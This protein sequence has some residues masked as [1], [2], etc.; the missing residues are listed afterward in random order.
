MYVCMCSIICLQCSDI[1]NG[2]TVGHLACKTKFLRRPL[3]TP[4]N[5]VNLESRRR[6][7]LCVF[8]VVDYA[9]DSFLKSPNLTQTIPNIGG[10]VTGIATLG[11]EIFV[12]RWNNP[13]IQVYKSSAD[14]TNVQRNVNVGAGTNTFRGLAACE[15]NQCLYVSEQNNLIIHK[16]SP[17]TNNTVKH[18]S[19]GGQPFGVTVNSAHNLLVACYNTHKVQEYTTDGAMVREINLQPDI[20]NPSYVVQ[21]QGDEFGVIENGSVY[22]YCVVGSDGKIVKSTASGQISSPYGFAVSKGGSKVFVADHGNNRMLLLNSK[23]LSVE[24]LPAA[25]NVGFNAPYC[26]HFDASAGVMYVGEWGL[27][28]IMCFKK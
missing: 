4:T 9:V 17:M 5:P 6:K 24:Q 23:S 25:F 15:F 27:G 2:H 20:A 7:L 21:L 26:I 3:W 8:N 28:R 22:R 1:F 16:V 14:D 11:D 18:W 19:V 12:V 10:S 13:N